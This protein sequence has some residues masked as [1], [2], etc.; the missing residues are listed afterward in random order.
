ME[1]RVLSCSVLAA[2][3]WAPVRIGRTEL[4]LSRN[5]LGAEGIKL[6]AAA[7]KSNVTLTQLDL[8]GNENILQY[9]RQQ[10]Q[11]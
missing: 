10:A 9:V 2:T 11:K 3:R 5:G 7:L 1:R 4:D 8:K 6:L